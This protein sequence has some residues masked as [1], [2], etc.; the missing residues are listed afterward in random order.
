MAFPTG[1]TSTSL[2]VGPCCTT[3]PWTETGIK[4][5]GYVLGFN[6]K[7]VLEKALERSSRWT[8]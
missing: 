3:H 6:N 5:N 2:V 7:M 1:G 4:W 8:C